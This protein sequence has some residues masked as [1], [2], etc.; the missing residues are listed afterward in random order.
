MKKLI[1]LT[2]LI[3][4]FLVFIAPAVLALGIK[5][6]PGD[7]QPPLEGTRGV[8]W[9][10]EVSQEFFSPMDNL[11]ALGMSIKNP[12]LKNKKDITLLLYDE[13]GNLVRKSVLNGQNI[14]DGAFVRFLF[15]P[16]KDSKNRHFK[17][18]LSAPDAGAEDLLEV[19]YTQK[20]PSWIGKMVAIEGVEESEIDGG[21]SLVTL[22]KPES[23]L[24][25][26]KTIYRG[27][28]AQ[29]STSLF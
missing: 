20:K 23:S 27:W 1:F 8:Y 7:L 17:F 24:F 9:I 10:F 16:V 29:I 4:L 11:T 21:V 3:V 6:L 25:V 28:L 15:D 13:N 5:Y 19:F 12:N 14:E 2:T 22:H 26:I 18:V